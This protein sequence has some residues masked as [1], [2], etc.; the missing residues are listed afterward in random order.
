MNWFVNLSLA[1]KMFVA[2]FTLLLGLGVVAL[3]SYL[4]ID[5][6][7]SAIRTL[8][9]V[10]IEAFADMAEVTETLSV[11]QLALYQLIT[12][13]VNES[14]VS[15]IEAQQKATLAALEAVTPTVEALDLT[16]LGSADLIARHETTIGHARDY[17][18]AALETSDM[19]VIDVATASIFMN[20]A[21]EQYD[22][23][24]GDVAALNET[25]NSM[26]MQATA[27][28][29]AGAQRAIML[30]LLTVAVVM[31]VSVALNWF[32]TRMISRPIIQII[33]S[34]TALAQGDREV[35]VPDANR[36]DEIGQMA[37]ALAVFQENAVERARLEE[38]QRAEQAERERRTQV[39]D[40]RIAQFDDVMKQEL[41][42]VT[43][44]AGNL[45]RNANQMAGAANMTQQ[46]SDAANKAAGDAA[47]N[48]QSVA[49]ATEELSSSIGEIGRQVDQSTSVA[50]RATDEARRTT[51]TIAELEATAQRI[52]TVITLIQEIASQTNLL[53]LNATIEAARAGDAGKGFA[54][55]AGEVKNLAAQ[56]AKA[57]EEIASSIS[58]IQTTTGKASE[59]IV[60]VS[61]IVDEM[62][63]I[64]VAVA[65]SVQE[66]GAAT[67]EIAQSVQ[68]LS[69]GTSDVTHSIGQVSEN[70]TVSGDAAGQV[71]DLSSGLAQ[72][73]ERLNST[74]RDFLRDVRAA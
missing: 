23:L 38:S 14:D 16:A 28:T 17:H 42:E 46:Q 26:R 66:Q 5:Q 32:V 47:L 9:D 35:E 57:T 45:E 72:Q 71:L 40:E 29:L 33:G 20:S 70:A 36:T 41:G 54:V 6:Q 48:V 18:K 60:G 49:S 27:G 56:T 43:S 10:Q 44:A 65:G 61:G 30:F 52:G 21:I 25:V 68:Q 50:S 19:A 74:I 1:K 8:N 73:S 62:A 3:I 4:A 34:M 12:T 13:A 39:I 53:A 37:E 24:R 7:R 31:A 58:E 11:A 22:I 55:V 51:E 69:S 15:K 59:A 2:P 67:Q 64:A 63:Q